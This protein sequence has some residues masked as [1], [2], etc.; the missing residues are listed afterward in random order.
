MP[1]SDPLGAL[2]SHVQDLAS[3][4]FESYS[5]LESILINIREEIGICRIGC[6]G[7]RER[8]YVTIYKL[9][10]IKATSHGHIIPLPMIYAAMFES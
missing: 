6:S 4:F 7:E 2:H 8:Y 3:V 10:S 1:F 5:S 9:I